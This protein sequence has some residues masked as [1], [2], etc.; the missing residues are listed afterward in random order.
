MEAYRRNNGH[1]Y[2]T[3]TGAQVLNDKKVH[4]FFFSGKWQITASNSNLTCPLSMTTSEFLIKL[5]K[6][7]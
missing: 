7:V 5:T 6:R 3:A 1:R 2:A 4:L